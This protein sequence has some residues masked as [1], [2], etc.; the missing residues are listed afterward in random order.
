MARVGAILAEV[1]EV[2]RQAVQPGVTTA[3]LN[4]VAAEAIV[5]RGGEPG[6]LGTYDYRH[7]LRLG[8]RGDR[9][10]HPVT[11]AAVL[12]GRAVRNRRG[13]RP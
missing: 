13:A 3:D 9:V 10:R 5:E 11:A 12:L 7:D 1:H 6:F 8:E 2:L 4:A